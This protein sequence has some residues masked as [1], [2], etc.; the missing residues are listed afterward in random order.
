MLS[1]V[2]DILVRLTFPIFLCSNKNYWLDRP[3]AI[4]VRQHTRIL[5]IIVTLCR[6]K[7]LLVIIVGL[8]L[9]QMQ[10]YPT[11]FAY[12]LKFCLTSVFASYQNRSKKKYTFLLEC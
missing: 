4:S 7:I 11:L 2:Y 10:Y 6:P 5:Y 12:P 3:M 8:C 1:Q 9:K